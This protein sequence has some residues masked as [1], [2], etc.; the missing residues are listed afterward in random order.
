M[1]RND[2]ILI[3]GIIA[4]AVLL[5]FII[6]KQGTGGAAVEVTADGKKFGTYSLA[7]DRKLEIKGTNVL[8]IKD[9]KADMIEADCP[10][11]ICV[12]QKPIFKTGESISCLP[13][14]V[15]VTVIGGE[16]NEIDAVVK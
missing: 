13:N 16:A 8:V 5:F 2:Y 12:K 11:K 15:I 9:G 7:E 3:T 14:K 10:D 6:G 4:A 1:K